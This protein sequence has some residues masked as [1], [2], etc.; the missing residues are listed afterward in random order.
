[1][2]KS[3]ATT[4]SVAVVEWVRVPLMPV[5]VTVELP[6]E[7]P[8]AV[9]TVSVE[10]PDPPAME[11]GEKESESPD[12]KPLAVKLT[13]PLKLFNAETVTLYVVLLPAL[14]VREAGVAAMVKSGFGGP[15]GTI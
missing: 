12:G 4:L 15:R 3:G 8:A 7:L 13:F 14:T 9:L 2:L 10:L 1:M 6:A 11:A 5:I